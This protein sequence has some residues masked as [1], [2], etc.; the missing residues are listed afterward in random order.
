VHEEQPG[1][2]FPLFNLLSSH[3]PSPPPPPQQILSTALDLIS[4]YNLLAKPSSLSTFNLALSLHTSVPR[5]EALYSW[6]RGAVDEEAL[7]V[8]GEG[9]ESWVEWRG[10]GFCEVE[11]LKSDMELSLEDESH[12]L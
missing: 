6:Y 3:I 1:S 2:Y 11:D 10:K 9:C 4:T 5:I 7:D 8:G 12:H